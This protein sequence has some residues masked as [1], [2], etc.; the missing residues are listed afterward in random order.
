M[1]PSLISAGKTVTT[2]G[3]P[4]V[5]RCDLYWPEHRTNGS[6]SST[7]YLWLNDTLVAPLWEDEKGVRTDRH[8]FSPSLRL[9]P[10][11]AH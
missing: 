3:F 6:A 8:A 2:T 11:P 1:L 4:L 7:Q 9:Q 10:Q 5:A